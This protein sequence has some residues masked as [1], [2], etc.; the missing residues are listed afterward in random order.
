MESE[1]PPRVQRP[2][3]ALYASTGGL[4][5]AVPAHRVSTGPGARK[6]SLRSG[7]LGP[8]GVAHTT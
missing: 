3:R 6:G 1:G 2:G 8:L 5:P 4:I 7:S